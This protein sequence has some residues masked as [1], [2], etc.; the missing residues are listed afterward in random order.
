MLESRSLLRSIYSL[1]V[2]LQSFKD[3][4]FTLTNGDD[5]DENQTYDSD[6]GDSY[7]MSSE[8]KSVNNRMSTFL[9]TIKK[10]KE[11]LQAC[12][13]LLKKFSKGKQLIFLDH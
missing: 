8:L 6:D 2:Y 13:T 12:L 10:Q 1:T 5:I 7:D 9:I 4:D 11:M 3:C